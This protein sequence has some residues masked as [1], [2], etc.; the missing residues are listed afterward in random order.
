MHNIPFLKPSVVKLDSYKELLQ[1]IDDSRIY[2][3]FG[4][5][6][7]RFETRIITE[8]FQNDGYCT[9]VN[10]CTLGLMLAIN[11]VK[12]ADA[13]YAVM[14]SF[15]FAATPQAAMWCG[16]EPYFVDIDGDDWSTDNAK[17][18]HAV[19][20]LG[21][22]VA[23][24]VPYATFANNINLN[25]YEDLQSKG[26]PV[27]IDAAPGLGS[28]H[29][30]VAFAKGFKG[31]TVFSLHATKGFGIGEGGLV[32]SANRETIDAV[33]KA[34]NFGFSSPGNSETLGLNAKM[35]EYAAAI[36]LATLD[37]FE[38]KVARRIEIRKMYLDGL[39]SSGLLSKGWRV[40]KS[41]GDI[42][43]QFFSLL[44]P[45]QDHLKEMALFMDENGIATRHYFSPCCHQQKCFQHYSHDNLNVTEKI[46]RSIISLPLWEQMTSEHIDHIIDTILTF[47]KKISPKESF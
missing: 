21:K 45:K 37:V 6:N 26:F 33:R 9:T 30:G 10:N 28:R 20:K 15:T 27:V 2:T 47:D 16:L 7:S 5:L 18:L 23:V 43:L 4:P 3:N 44:L 39:E 40:Q 41:Y 22:D 32:Y 35:S 8:L 13:K 14:P 38:H 11:A 24:I 1:E 34:S 42:P 31:A 17:L 19:E 12:K 29:N 46:A 36:A 25:I